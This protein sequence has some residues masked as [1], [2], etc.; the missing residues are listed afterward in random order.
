MTLQPDQ[1]RTLDYLHQFLEPVA[2]LLQ[3]PA[4]TELMINGP[5]PDRVFVE[6][7]G[8][9]RKVDG[10][11]ID[12]DNLLAA[13]ANVASA[14]H[15]EINA[16][17]P[18]MDARLADGSRVAAMLPPVAVDGPI[19]TVRKFGKR[20]S[21]DELEEGGSV[22]RVVADELRASVA[23]GRTILIS[24]GTGTGKTTLLNAVA[25]CLP[26]ES[27]VALIEDT[28]EIHLEQP[29]LVRLEARP[30][31]PPRG[32]EPAQPPITI[33]Q[34]LRGTLRHRPDRI[35]LGEV[36][37]AEAFDLLQA[38]N[39]GHLGSLS[40]IHANSATQALTRLAH[41]VLMANIGLPH[42]AVREAITL[43]INRVVH[44]ARRGPRR[45]VVE[46]LAVTGYDSAR[47]QFVYES[48]YTEDGRERSS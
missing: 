14:C 43:A 9:V 45:V 34:L 22:P 38:L 1:L 28:S 39:T 18:L 25:A 13:I 16:D 4:V 42:N 33:A 6:R 20:Y 44:I 26:D 17:K 11:S 29:N 19:L 46:L 8:V 31:L 2:H 35:I 10:V 23:E 27:R 21:L 5:G 7:G 36:R 12:R 3:D 24:G 41:C 37:G 15:D 40:T 48:L 32:G 47:D 30:E